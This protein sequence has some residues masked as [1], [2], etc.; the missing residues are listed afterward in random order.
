MEF[1]A[2]EIIVLSSCLEVLQE[3]STASNIGMA[4]WDSREVLPQDLYCA[5]EGTRVDG[6]DFIA[7]ALER[8]AGMIALTHEVDPAVMVRAQELGVW[9][10]RISS[11]QAFLEDLARAWRNQLSAFV[12]GLTGSLG[13][14][15]TKGLLRDIVG[16]RFKVSATQGN[17]NNEL[18]VPATIL[19]C[20]RDA[21]ILI[22]EMGMRGLG[23]IEELCSYVRPHAA[24]ITTIGISHIELL[25]SQENIARAKSEICSHLDKRAE[26]F[27]VLNA[28]DGFASLI[29]DYAKLKD[30]GVDILGFAGS[31]EEI[32]D[33]EGLFNDVAYFSEK[34]RDSRGFLQGKLTIDGNSIDCKI[35]LRGEHNYV[36]AAAA[37]LAAYKLGMSLDQI[38]QALHEVKTESGR[39]EVQEVSLVSPLDNDHEI[40]F[41]IINDAYNAN[42]SSMAS[43]LD[44]LSLFA[45]SS[46]RIAILGGM[47]ELGE[48]ELEAHQS[49]GCYLAEKSPDLF[50]AVG[51]L[52]KIIAQSASNAGY[53]AECILFADDAQEAYALLCSIVHAEDVVLL[54][55]S[56]SY[57]L[58]E[59]IRRFD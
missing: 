47:G 26:S 49:I 34:S 7:S 53:P 15:S 54:K 20:P 56:H 39:L 45:S 21:E 32:L 59:I 1:T 42:P 43:A 55:G 51:D 38:A 8:G 25:G 31:L 36:N 48:C 58:E 11:L 19:Q 4:R 41:C 50:I 10:V 33:S 17:Q 44:E 2:Q 6:H 40:K 30:S 35:S 9:V 5:F 52:A 23:Q 24:L 37:V 57:G 27:V 22:V 3:G 14:T 13:K 29:S 12:I 16:T 18:G 28:Q 46:R